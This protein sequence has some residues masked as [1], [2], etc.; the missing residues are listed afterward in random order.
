MFKARV[1]LDVDGVLNASNPQFDTVSSFVFN[2]NL[3]GGL[4]IKR[5]FTFSPNLVAALDAMFLKYNVELVWLSTWNDDLKVL[6]LAK[7]FGGLPNGRVLHCVLP[8]HRNP[9]LREWTAWKAKAIL[10]DQRGDETPF[11]WADDEALRFHR[12]DVDAGVSADVPR[13]FLDPRSYHGLT[14][15][16]LKKMDNFFSN[17]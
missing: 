10:D 8:W 15:L 6:R 14:K 7:N 13:L 11:V 16:D 9:T 5:D 2:D 3:G 4:V 12:S 17:L 1:Y